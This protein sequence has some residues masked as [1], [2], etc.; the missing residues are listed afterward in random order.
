MINFTKDIQS[1]TAFRRNS[2]DLMK[3]LKKTKRPI[4]LTVNGKAEAVVQDAKSY[5]RLLDIAARG[6]ASGGIR[7]AKEEM[8]LGLDR[9]FDEFV[10]EFKLKHGLSR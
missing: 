8:K 3:Q 9:D 7:Q 1:L 2:G 6:D 5:Q 10:A 4:I